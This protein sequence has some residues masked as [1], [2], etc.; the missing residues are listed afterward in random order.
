MDFLDPSLI[1]Y[2]RHNFQELTSFSPERVWVPSLPQHTSSDDIYSIDY[3]LGHWFP[4]QDIDIL[5]LCVHKHIRQGNGS[6][7][8][9]YE[10]SS[11]GS[12]TTF[13]YLDLREYI[14]RTLDSLAL[15]SFSPDSIVYVIHDHSICSASL[16]LSL[17][18]LNIP[19]SV[20]FPS[21]TCSELLRRFKLLSPS[22]IFVQTS[23]LCEENIASFLDSTSSYNLLS[24]ESSTVFE[25]Q[26]S[27]K[28]LSFNSN[29]D[30][31]FCLFTSGSTGNPKGVFHSRCGYLMY[32]YVT[33][34]YFWNLCTSDVFLCGSEL[35]WINGHTYS[36]FGPLLCGA[37]SV[38][39]ANPRTLQDCA[40]F[41]KLL[42]SLSV[43]CVYLP[44]ALIRL[45]RSQSFVLSCDHSVRT[46]GSMGEPLAPSVRLW[47]SLLF[48]NKP[49]PVVN[50]YFQTETGGIL[51][52][53]R[54]SDPP[55][56]RDSYSVG[57]IPPFMEIDTDGDPQAL[58]VTQPWPG[59]PRRLFGD[60][61]KLDNYFNLSSSFNLFDHGY[62]DESQNLFV[63]GRSDD[64]LV[65]QGK[66]YDSA[67]I[68]SVA[69]SSSSNVRDA[70]AFLMTDSNE[71]V[72]LCLAF[73]S[74]D[75]S[76][77]F[78]DFKNSVKRSVYETCNGLIVRS[79]Y[80]ANYI[81]KNRS[82][83]ILRNRLRELSISYN[84]F[85]PLNRPKEMIFDFGEHFSNNVFT[86]V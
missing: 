69:L 25:C 21:S 41:S 34:K 17:A 42:F 66:N 75:S 44:V 12:I 26:Y 15:F 77:D 71:N 8:A 13:T 57:H 51:V 35:G 81:A 32:A 59:S 74:I 52:A 5:D 6:S 55:L 61:H 19:F 43:T 65:I 20:V 68:E 2:W 56:S 54:Y 58:A 22:H 27:S 31:L 33:C 49:T 78:T 63:F 45:M 24:F 82:G 72:I 9:F 7:V 46:I 11:C 48:F 70:V 80:Y 73:S 38:L 50:T 14:Y 83:K 76:L 40:S 39:I 28:R 86:L 3:P 67:A 10:V 79:F 4:D 23:Y 30:S 1:E 47:Y 53:Q 36:L 18:H 37:S 62:I 85:S 16:L 64:I 60:K 29:H 84:G